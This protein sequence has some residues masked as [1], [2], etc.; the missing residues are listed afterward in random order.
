M[1]R[2][3]SLRRP[4]ARW[5]RSPLNW[6]QVKVISFLTMKAFRIWPLI[7]KGIVLTLNSIVLATSSWHYQANS[8][9]F[10]NPRFEDDG[11]GYWRYYPP[12]LS[13]GALRWSNC[14]DVIN[15]LSM[16]VFRNWLPIE[17]T[18]FSIGSAMSWVLLW[19]FIL[20]KAVFGFF[21]RILDSG[22]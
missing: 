5:R 22:L 18:L 3:A 9:W 11:Y 6:Y 12:L 15:P 10:W 16:Q 7:D 2:W 19:L 8:V 13:K 1:E 4:L 20:W 21:A 17:S 14:G